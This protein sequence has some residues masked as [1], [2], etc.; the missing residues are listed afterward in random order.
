[1]SISLHLPHSFLPIF[2]LNWFFTL[3]SPKSEKF[4][5]YE[6]LGDKFQLLGNKTGKSQWNK[7]T[8]K[9]FRFFRTLIQLDI[10]PTFRLIFL[11]IFTLLSSSR[12]NSES[13][14]LLNQYWRFKRT[15]SFK[16]RKISEILY[17]KV[18]TDN[19]YV[20]LHIR[21]P[22]GKFPIKI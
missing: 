13:D 10:F 7:I 15:F 21:K 14:S 5:K 3:I 18:D 11:I 1:M 19:G 12:W 6:T 9:F 20:C 16:S 8:K 22:T 2:L 17:S 4:S